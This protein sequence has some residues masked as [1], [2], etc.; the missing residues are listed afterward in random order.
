MFVV[1]EESTGRQYRF[2]MPGTE[3]CRREAAERLFETGFQGFDP[4]H[5]L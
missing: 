3:L 1:L 4:S 2:G 5:L